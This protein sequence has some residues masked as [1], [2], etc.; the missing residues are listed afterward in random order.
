MNI[1]LLGAELGSQFQQIFFA[2]ET[3]VKEI[4]KERDE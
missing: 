1:L 4:V 3:G 2:P